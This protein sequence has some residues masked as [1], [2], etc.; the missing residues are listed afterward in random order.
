MF[1]VSVFLLDTRKV[2]C[3]GQNVHFFNPASSPKQKQ[4]NKMKVFCLICFYFYSFLLQQSYV[5]S[6]LKYRY[7]L[8]EMKTIKIVSNLHV[9]R[10]L[11]WHRSGSWSSHP[12]CLGTAYD[13]LYFL[14][15]SYLLSVEWR[16]YKMKMLAVRWVF[17]FT[18]IDGT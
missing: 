7:D 6:I 16:K 10:V 12:Q 2:C 8:L 9:Q 5:L 1:F 17:L 18:P 15:F 13:L 4:T 11:T 14:T 3:K